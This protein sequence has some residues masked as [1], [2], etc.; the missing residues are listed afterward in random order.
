MSARPVP[1]L[2]GPPPRA[3]IE[4]SGLFYYVRVS[5]GIFHF[6]R[7]GMFALTRR[8]AERKGRRWVAHRKRVAADRERSPLMVVE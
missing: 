7:S 3:E 8:S 4:R 2:A 6:E 1:R 5:E